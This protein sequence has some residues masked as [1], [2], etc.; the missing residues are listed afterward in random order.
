MKPMLVMIPALC[1]D[2][3]LYDGFEAALGDLA[4]VKIVSVA[5]P[6]F[7]QCGAQILEAVP[8]PFIAMGTSFGGHVARELALAAPERVAGLWIIGAGAGAVADPAGGRARGEALRGGREEEIYEAFAK[9]ITHL[10]GPRGPEARDRFL[11]MARRGDPMRA[12]L[13]NDALLGRIDRWDAL[14]GI[15]CPALLL[16]G[17]HDQFSPAADGLR[18]AGLIPKA[19]F[20]ELPGCGHLPTLEAAEET[21]DAARH[22]LLDNFS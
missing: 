16:W 18:M 12:A 3:G 8:G 5:A 1:C 22:W 7:A 20:V 14:P 4:D 9:T 11:A 15:A 17:R 6:G 13:Q 2:A 19:R 10:P 21:V